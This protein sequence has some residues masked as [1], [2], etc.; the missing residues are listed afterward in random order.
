MM[1]VVFSLM[2]WLSRK[3]DIQT[4]YSILHAYIFLKPVIP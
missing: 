4:T 3:T 2:F 1:F